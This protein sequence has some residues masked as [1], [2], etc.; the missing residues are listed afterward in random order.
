[1]N[2]FFTDR[3][4]TH[5]SE[6]VSPETE[7]NKSLGARRRCPVDTFSSLTSSPPGQFI[8]PTSRREKKISPSGSVLETGRLGSRIA[9]GLYLLLKTVTKYEIGRSLPKYQIHFVRC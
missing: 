9:V 1:M 6:K 7:R 8:W 4:I 3:T 5:D 2:G